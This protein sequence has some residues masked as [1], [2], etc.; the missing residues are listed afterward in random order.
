M[1]VHFPE[2]IERLS[3]IRG[4]RTTEIII[5]RAAV[6]RRPSSLRITFCGKDSRTRQSEVDITCLA[7]IVLGTVN[8]ITTCMARRTLSITDRI[9]CRA[10]R[11][12]LFLGCS[13]FARPPTGDGIIIVRCHRQTGYV[14]IDITIRLPIFQRQTGILCTTGKRNMGST[15]RSICTKYV[16]TTVAY[17]QHILKL[18]RTINIE[19][20]INDTIIRTPVIGTPCRFQI[21]RCGTSCRPMCMQ[22]LICRVGLLAEIDLCSSIS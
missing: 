15:G 4:I 21:N 3:G 12:T 2:R 14:V 13:Y 17:H 19:M 1:S 11:T 22:R 5:L 8:R 20:C 10:V 18:I 6:T 7:L 16:I 9:G